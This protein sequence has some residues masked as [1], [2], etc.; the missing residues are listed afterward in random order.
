MRQYLIAAA[1]VSAAAAAPATAQQSGLVNVDVTN[2]LNDLELDLLN[3]SLNDNTVQV[4]IGVAANVC[5][6]DANVLASQ[7]KASSP[8][9]CTASNTSK[10][11]KQAA[12]KQAV[13]KAP[14]AK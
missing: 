10:A 14:A 7:R 12:K 11:L 6:V 4:P 3:N 1:L 8:A 13:P 5:G 2:V 9:K